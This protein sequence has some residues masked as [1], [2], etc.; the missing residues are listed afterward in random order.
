MKNF[1][2]IIGLLVPSLLYAQNPGYMGKKNVID[3]SV[4][5]SYPLIHNTGIWMNST[6]FYK[7]KNN[8]LVQ[9]NES[10]TYGYRL[11]FSHAFSRKFG[12]ALEIG[13]N[14]MQ[15]AMPN[16]ATIY[17]ENLDN[18]YNN[19]HSL[20]VNQEAF[21]IIETLIMPKIEFST[22]DGLLPIGVVHQ[23]GFGF[24]MIKI[25]D[26]KYLSYVYSDSDDNPNPTP[27]YTTN[28]YDKSSVF[29]SKT[30]FYGFTVKTPISKSVL[31]NYGVRYTLNL[32]SSKIN[33]R[34]AL[35]YYSGKTEEYWYTEDELAALIK[36][37]NLRSFI[38]LHFGV[39]YAF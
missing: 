12:L 38:A 6:S 31:L 21:R 22:K 28:L 24:G 14:S 20:Y 17:I 1:I 5:G 35:D 11:N 8:K 36:H 15:M 23:I 37:R 30:L 27:D 10:F 4:S 33:Y 26:Q 29:K 16:G 13:R 32:V 19:H 39:S 34:Q 2:I 3:L 18:F 25:K 7:R 9:G